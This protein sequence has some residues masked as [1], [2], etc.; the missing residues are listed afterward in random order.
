M[1][2][3]RRRLAAAVVLA[4]S[5]TACRNAP[6]SQTSQVIAAQKRE[7]AYRANNR[8]V[9]LMEQDAYADAARAFR[10]ALTTDAGLRLARINLP[11]A[12]YYAGQLP[13]A[14]QAARNTSMKN[15]WWRM[16]RSRNP[17]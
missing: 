9:A 5:C 12:L 11:I 3:T 7:A 10:E 2:S 1:T 16:Q 13:E 14:M 6:P 15:F 17:W 8:G 4:A